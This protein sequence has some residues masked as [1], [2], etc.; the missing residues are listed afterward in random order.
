MKK[1]HITIRYK[2]K[3][4]LYLQMPDKNMGVGVSM[5][6]CVLL[7][8]SVVI[9]LFERGRVRYDDNE[10]GFLGTG[11]FCDVAGKFWE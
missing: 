6:K 4:T 7:E 11:G 1:L 5:G 3:I 9:I 10:C 2:L 8:F